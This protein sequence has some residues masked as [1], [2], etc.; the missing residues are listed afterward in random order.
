M[1]AFLA[2][3]AANHA[4]AQPDYPAKPVR[5][6]VNFAA[7][8]PSDIV[9][10]LLGQKLAE[11]WEK[12]VLVE[13]VPGAAG[14]IGAER[15]AKATPDGYTILLTGSSIVAG[16][17]FHDRTSYDPLRDL[18][19][20]TRVCIVPNLLVVHPSVPA[21]SVRE[22]VALAKA[23]R[24][25]LT[26]A[27]AGDGSTSHLSGELF[28]AAAGLDIRHVP[29]KGAGA[30][31]PD[32]VSGR[33]TM[34]IAPIATLLPLAR[35]GKLR[36]L[37]VAAT[38]RS[39]AAPEL[40]TIA[41]SGFPGF[42]TSSWQ[43]FFAPL[44]TPASVVRKIQVDVSRVTAQPEVNARLVELGMERVASSPGE[45]AAVIKS[46]VEKW[47]KVIKKS[48]AKRDLDVSARRAPSANSSFATTSVTE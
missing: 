17:V 2:A 38:K 40:P 3:V 24:G 21:K 34:T 31:I 33:V 25:E 4:A 22:L 20:V 35:A 8:G 14:S 42:D 43:G 41:E 39:P 9:A 12:P 10:R 23:R 48:G 45:F 46:E 1:L 26:F 7:G 29:Y 15:V 44:D 30:I 11:R 32:L 37:A 13:N 47:E 16:S 19:A 28:N 6:I 18:T 27:S 36:A 5:I